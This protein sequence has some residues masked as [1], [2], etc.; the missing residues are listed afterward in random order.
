MTNYAV[1]VA[2]LEGMRRIHVLAA[3]L[4]SA[5]TSSADMYRALNGAT[6]K[7]PYTGLPFAWSE[8]RQAVI[9]RGLQEGARGEHVAPL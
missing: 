6:T 1:R 4:R 3:D 2:D 9:F 8:T 5:G 7:D